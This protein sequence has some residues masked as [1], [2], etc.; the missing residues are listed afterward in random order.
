MPNLSISAALE[1]AGPGARKAV[2]AKGVRCIVYIEKA[3]GE[4]V[5]DHAESYEQASNIARAWIDDMGAR[6]CSI[7]RLMTRL[8]SPSSQSRRG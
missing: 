3:N 4:W 1:E 7:W 8:A 6:G 5:L 2:M